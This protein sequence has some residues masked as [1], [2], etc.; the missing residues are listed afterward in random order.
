MGADRHWLSVELAEGGDPEAV[1]SALEP[2]GGIEGIDL[3][4]AAEDREELLAL[5]DD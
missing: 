5:L 4:E 1:R 3:P 2:H